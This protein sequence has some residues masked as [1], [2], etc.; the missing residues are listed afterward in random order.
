MRSPFRAFTTVIAFGAVVTAGALTAAP[1]L[2]QE[3]TLTGQVRP[4]FE[5]RDPVAGGLDDFTSMRVRLGVDALIER[6]LSVFVQVQDV[7][8]WGEESHPL[9]DFSADALDLHQG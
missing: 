8:I 7:R 2:A 5:F 1:V 9:F 6:G 3:V 4:R